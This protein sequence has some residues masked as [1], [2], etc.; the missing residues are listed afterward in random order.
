[1][2]PP[3]LGKDLAGLL[4]SGEA[5]DITF[6]VEGEEM[7]AHRIVLQARPAPASRRTVATMCRETDS[8]PAGPHLTL[9]FGI[10]T[11]F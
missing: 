9:S 5:S 2:P 11:C 1:M 3:S 10:Q 4:E 8:A 6:K 7:A